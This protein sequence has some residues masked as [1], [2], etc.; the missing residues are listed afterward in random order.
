M[1][2]REHMRKNSYRQLEV[3]QIAVDLAE[4]TYHLTCKFPDDERFGLTSQM[5]RTAVSVASNIAEGAGRQ[6]RKEFLNHLSMAKGSLCEL[7][8]QLTIAVKLKFA[9]RDQ[10]L[11]MWDLS[12]RVG[13]MLTKLSQSLKSQQRSTINDQR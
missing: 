1:V 9:T 13:K 7:E 6:G 4:I 2:Y 10:A 11:A 3:W 8:T 12:Q 5:R